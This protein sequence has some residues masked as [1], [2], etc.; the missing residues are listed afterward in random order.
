LSFKQ[1]GTRQIVK[2]SCAVA[3][4]KWITMAT[5]FTT[6]LFSIN[7]S[8]APSILAVW[9]GALE[10]ATDTRIRETISKQRSDQKNVTLLSVEI[11]EVTSS[12]N[13]RK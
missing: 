5:V 11:N 6:Y 3:Q 4:R 1:G 10:D 8:E 13:F 7:E 12:P 2:Q 9:K